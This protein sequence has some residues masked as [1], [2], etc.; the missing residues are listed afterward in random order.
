MS[1]LGYAG[2]LGFRLRFLLGLAFRREAGKPASYERGA[3]GPIKKRV[4]ALN[5]A[6]KNTSGAETASRNA[7]PRLEQDE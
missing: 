2:H 5:V 4:R 6:S 3:R 7:A 1:D